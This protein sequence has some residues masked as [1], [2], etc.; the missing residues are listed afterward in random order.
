MSPDVPRLRYH[1]LG[2]ADRGFVMRY[3]KKR[4]TGYSRKKVT[5]LV[6]RYLDMGELK[7]RYGPPVKGFTGIHDLRSTIYGLAFWF[8]SHELQVTDSPPPANIRQGGS[9]VCL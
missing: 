9:Q 7:K 2:K 6:R 8:P 3:L 4:T 1:A 5:R